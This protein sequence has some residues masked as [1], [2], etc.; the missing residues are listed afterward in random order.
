MTQLRLIFYNP[1]KYKQFI[2]LFCKNLHSCLIC[3]SHITFQK[4]HILHPNKTN[5]W[6]FLTSC[7]YF[8]WIKAR[9]T[10]GDCWNES[11]LQNFPRSCRWCTSIQKQPSTKTTPSEIIWLSSPVTI[12]QGQ[13]GT[14]SRSDSSLLV[15]LFLWFWAHA[16]LNA[17]NLN[18]NKKESSSNT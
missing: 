10:Q 8:N 13:A 6:F 2:D 15:A 3:F 14:T 1:R 7:N 12:T 9:R 5:V 11:D 4:Y 18:W 17:C 16:L